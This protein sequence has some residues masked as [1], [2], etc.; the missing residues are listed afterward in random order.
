MHESPC[1]HNG[2]PD[3]HGGKSSIS[4]ASK[5]SR[6]N[7]NKSRVHWNTPQAKGLDILLAALAASTR[8]RVSSGVNARQLWSQEHLLLA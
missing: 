6:E 1:L 4:Q 3:V 8:L 2:L 5:S 7:Q